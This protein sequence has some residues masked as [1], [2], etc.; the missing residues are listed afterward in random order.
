VSGAENDWTT[1][2]KEVLIVLA[3]VGLTLGATAIQLVPEIAG[4][5]IAMYIVE[6]P[7]D[8]GYGASL[9]DPEKTQIQQPDSAQE[10]RTS[11]YPSP[12]Y[13]AVLPVLLS[14]V[15]TEQETPGNL[16]TSGQADTG[17]RVQMPSQSGSIPAEQTGQT[18]SEEGEKDGVLVSAVDTE[19]TETS[20]DGDL[21]VGD[22]SQ[23]TPTDDH[24]L[25]ALMRE[26]PKMNPDGTIF[27]PI[28]TQR[29]FAIRT[30]VGEI[31]SAPIGI[32]L[33]GRVVVNPSSSIL[34]QASYPGVLEKVE[35]RFPYV[36]QEVSRGQ[37]LAKL[38]PI[39]NHLAEA[40]IREKITELSNHIELAKKRMAM[41]EE[42]VY[43]RY[44]VNK[45]E[46]IR[47]EIQGLIRRISVLEDSLTKSYEL[48][49]QTDGVISEIGVMAGQY[50]E[51]GITL[52]RIIDPTMLWVE[53]SGYQ[54]GLQ[55]SIQS[56]TALTIEGES[57]NLRF[58]GGG[59]ALSN[60]AIPLLF[61]VVG[62]EI[63]GLA[64]DNPVTV[65]VQTEEDSVRGIKV[66]RS[67]IARSTDGAALIWS[68]ISPEE[69]LQHRVLV[70]PIDAEHVLVLDDI[71]ANPRVVS[72]GVGVLAQI[73]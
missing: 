45:I 28:A 21:E 70:T 30:V 13:G 71:T 15:V 57:I 41:L 38:R 10:F 2:R 18:Q 53:A 52:F 4:E 27:L 62:T 23:S 46:E 55:K 24:L 67:S 54:R 44:R 61:E 3:I 43:V 49:A 12:T 65:F 48:R 26:K 9:E 64:I 8:T 32:E 63:T 42:V 51:E 72:E 22:S 58:V 20:D 73:R 69:F 37:L 29:A 16:D 25:L 5:A 60:Q 47:T 31:T 56:A 34:V 11:I 66:P 59:L 14:A 7:E 35:G 40:Q 19:T 39:N 6:P 36:G 50:V 1:R 33:P 68:K 17:D